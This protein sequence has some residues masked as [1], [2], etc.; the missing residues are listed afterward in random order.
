MTNNNEIQAALDVDAIQ[1]IV[2]QYFEEVLKNKSYSGRTSRGATWAR[3]NDQLNAIRADLTAKQ[4]AYDDG[5][6][7]SECLKSREYWRHTAHTLSDR[8]ARLVED[9]ETARNLCKAIVDGYP[10]PEINHVDFRV[11]VTKWAQDF[12]DN[13]M[14]DIAR[15]EQ[16]GQSHE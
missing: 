14:K 11:Q 4:R 15:A 16:K 5:F 1:S 10:N 2:D 3:A 7:L 9:L 12:L 13:D 6:D 8:N